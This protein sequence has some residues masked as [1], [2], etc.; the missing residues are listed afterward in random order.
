M[1]STIQYPQNTYISNLSASVTGSYV[2]VVPPPASSVADYSTPNVLMS[3]PDGVVRFFHFAYIAKWGGMLDYYVFYVADGFS[4]ALPTY[5]D[6]NS[7]VI[8]TPGNVY[9]YS[10]LGCVTTQ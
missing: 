4:M 9:V 10:P 3:S 8:V 5:C 2:S 1:Y 7:K 6:E